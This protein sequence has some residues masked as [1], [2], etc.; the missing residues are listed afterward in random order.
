M[1]KYD[2]QMYFTTRENALQGQKNSEASSASTGCCTRM[3][4]VL[5]NGFTPVKQ[6]M[7]SRGQNVNDTFYAIERAESH[8]AIHIL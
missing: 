4:V 3:N 6:N 5:K 7:T 2:P 8:K 1:Q